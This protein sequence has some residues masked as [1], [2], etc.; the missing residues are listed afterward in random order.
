M[1]LLFKWLCESWL[2]YLNGYVSLLFKW[3]EFQSWLYYLNGYECFTSNMGMLLGLYKQAV[4]LKGVNSNKVHTHCMLGNIL[5]AHLV[6][7]FGIIVIAI[8]SEKPYY[9]PSQIYFE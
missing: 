7:A 6:L 3:L 2:Y 1:A 8:A 5:M 4:K 9:L